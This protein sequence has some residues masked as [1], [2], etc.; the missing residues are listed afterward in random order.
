MDLS[1][2]YLGLDLKNPFVPSSSP[3]SKNLDAAKRLEDND[4]AA[5]VMYSLFEEEIE[6]DEARAQR[7]AHHQDIGHGEASSYL[8]VPDDFPSKRDE[9]LEQLR[10]LKDAL[11]IPV[12]ASLNGTTPGGWMRHAK[13]LEEAGADALELNVYYVAADLEQDST[14]VEQRVVNVLEALHGQVGLSIGVKLS[15]YFSAV[16]HLIRRLEQAGAAAVALFNRFYQPDI[17]L[18]TLELAQTIRL[19]TSAES[20]LAMR[21]IAI[22]YGRVKLSLAATG[23]VHT[24][25]DALKLFLCG[26]DV[27]YLC[28]VLLT[29]GPEKLTEIRRGVEQWLEDHEYESIEQLKGSMSQQHSPD[30]VAFE[31]GNYIKTLGSFRLPPSV[32][33]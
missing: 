30:P 23:G 7:L 24:A 20:L 29:G 27:T 15:P 8:P 18:D 11:D 21:W 31:R 1:T 17:D 28:S 2:R 14:I 33:R 22:L 3:L 12:I 19:S 4:A 32:W 6:L 25:E 26:A 9:Y 10:R 5:L 13:A 16:G